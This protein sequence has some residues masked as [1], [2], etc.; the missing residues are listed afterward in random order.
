MKSTKDAL[1]YDYLRRR[2]FFVIETFVK[3]AT[4]VRTERKD[5]MKNR[6]NLHIDRQPYLTNRISDGIMRRAT[7]IIDVANDTVVKNRLRATVEA[8]DDE[9][10]EH[11]KREYSS[12]FDQAR[13]G[14]R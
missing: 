10:L 1:K 2:P 5:W 9:I 3:P 7:I 13:W 11:C 4:K 12:W 8:F 6:L 14:M